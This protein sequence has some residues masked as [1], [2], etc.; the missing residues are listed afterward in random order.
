MRNAAELERSEACMRS[1]SSRCRWDC[2]LPGEGCSQGPL[3]EQN[4][5]DRDYAYTRKIYY[6]TGIKIVMTA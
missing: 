6:C 5:G 4:E 2:G 1:C 3:E